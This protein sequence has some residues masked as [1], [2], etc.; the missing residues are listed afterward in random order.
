[1][2]KRTLPQASEPDPQPTIM[3]R[4]LAAAHGARYVQLCAFAIDVDRVYGEQP[5]DSELPFGWEVFLTECY[6]VGS[7]DGS[8]AAQ[9]TLIEETCLALLEQP[10][11]EQGHGSQLLFAIYDAIERGLY[12]KSLRGLFR[13]WRSRPRQLQRALDALWAD[14]ETSLRALAAHCLASGVELSAPTR[15]AL[16]AMRGGAWPLRR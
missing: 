2:S 4:A 3:D 6:A 1:M 5:E 7:L 16:V 11:D 8:D 14:A 10:P 15:R 13:S 12:P 9:R